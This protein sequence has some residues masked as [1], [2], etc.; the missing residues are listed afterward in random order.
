MKENINESIKE[1]LDH[2]NKREKFDESKVKVFA[3]PYPVTI[4]GEDND[5]LGGKSISIAL[6][7]YSILLFYPSSNSEIRIY[8]KEIPGVFKVFL[9]NIG[10]YIKNDWVSFVKGSAIELKKR[11]NI[12]E[13][14]TGV[15]S[16][17]FPE[18]IEKK[19][20]IIQLCSLFALSDV[21]NLNLN[22]SDHIQTC[23]DIDNNFIKQKY[24]SLDPVTIKHSKKENLL[25]VDF[26]INKLKHLKN[27][28]DSGD[29]KFIILN[30]KNL[31]ENTLKD[32]SKPLQAA[33]LLGMMA[34]IGDANDYSKITSDNFEEYKSKIPLEFQKHAF[35]FFL[36]QEIL[37]QSKKFWENNDLVEFG[38]LLKNSRNFENNEMN[39]L[40]SKINSC[41]SI[42]GSKLISG[43]QIL[44]IGKNNRIIETVEETINKVGISDQI[45][46]K[47][48]SISNGVMHS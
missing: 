31:T 43:F 5:S 47:I 8:C 39:N 20:S 48:S 36:E 13:G 17:P 26:G 9:N 35:K 15:L 18:A 30:P 1:L 37:N 2:L 28:R 44:G 41:G 6:D 34:G 14:F 12:K 7:L 42:Y 46:F 22:I 4:F 32:Y 27:N 3:C 25:M 11:F 19:P 21:N 23:E 33:K 45:D 40:L 38:K 16:V 24:L 10:A 29:Y